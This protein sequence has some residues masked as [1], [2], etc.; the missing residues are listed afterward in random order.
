MQHEYGLLAVSK[1]FGIRDR[2]L[3]SN[4]CN[5]LQERFW[6]A[7]GCPKWSLLFNEAQEKEGFS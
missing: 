2:L 5:R 6:V 3:S 7:F 1:L 4:R